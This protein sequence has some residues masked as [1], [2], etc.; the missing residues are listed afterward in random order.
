MHSLTE[1][2]AT[3]APDLRAWRRDFHRYAESGWQEFRTAAK[4]ADILDGLGYEL[5]VGRDVV[6]ADSRMGLPDAQTLAAAYQRARQQGAPERWL[7]AF[8]GGFTGI[9]ATL[10]TGRPGPTL[11]FRVD[12][13]ALDLEEDRCATS[14]RANAITAK[15]WRLSTRARP[16]TKCWI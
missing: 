2:I 9:V 10:R 5:A 1:Y 16:S 7:P 11:G 12:M 8:E 6:D 14:A 13:D 15:P 4:V 3:L